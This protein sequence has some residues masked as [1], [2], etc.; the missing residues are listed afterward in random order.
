M[1]YSFLNDYVNKCYNISVDFQDS[2][3]YTELKMVQR[4]LQ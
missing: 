2:K 1:S 3:N 4:L